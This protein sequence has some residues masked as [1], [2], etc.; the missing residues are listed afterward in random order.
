V[1][2]REVAA[3][4]ALGRSNREI[5]DQMVVSERTV[6]KH[7][8]NILAKLAFSS[9]SQIAAWAVARTLLA[10]SQDRCR[11]S[12]CSPTQNS[13]RIYV[14]APPNLR[15]ST[16]PLQALL[17]MALL[18]E[19]AVPMMAKQARKRKSMPRLLDTRFGHWMNYQMAVRAARKAT[20][21]SL[22]QRY[23]AAHSNLL[24]LLDN[25]HAEE[26]NLPTAYPDGRPLTME[27]VF[28]VPTEHFELHAAWIQQALNNR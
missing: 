20:R 9:R 27:T 6:E 12:L 28:H 4:I 16:H 26:W 8:E 10:S 5:G 23:N 24:Q 17:C 13:S 21:A 22:A 19:Q 2:E 7:V 14:L 11:S 18:V 3:L 25:V 15:A 1:R